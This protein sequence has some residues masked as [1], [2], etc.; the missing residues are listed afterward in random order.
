MF[1]RQFKWLISNNL[2]GSLRKLKITSR[3]YVSAGVSVS[4]RGLVTYCMVHEVILCVIR[5]CRVRNFWL[6]F[7]NT[8]GLNGVMYVD[9]MRDSRARLKCWNFSR[10]T[11]YSK[12]KWKIEIVRNDLEQMLLIIYIIFNCFC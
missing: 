4:E 11:S 8:I 12:L 1:R 6:L 10:G 2:Y 9:P 7:N 3:Y 5:S